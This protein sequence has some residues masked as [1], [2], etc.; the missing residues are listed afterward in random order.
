VAGLL[1]GCGGGAAS[2]QTVSGNGYHFGA[3]AGWSVTRTASSAA[4]SSGPVSLVEIVTF[5][6]ARAYQP[7]LFARSIGELD[8]VAVR[9]ARQLHGRVEA[10]ATAEVAGR[11]ARSYSLAYRA[12]VL[13]LTFVFEGRQEYELLCR[14]PA[15]LVS[16]P[17]CARLLASFG[18]A[19]VT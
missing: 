5:R 3:P 18:L 16:T 1:A 6:L 10:G 4:A 8:Q 14:R 2:W 15:T 17:V 11:Q 19:G 13:Q 12:R 7:R 9:I